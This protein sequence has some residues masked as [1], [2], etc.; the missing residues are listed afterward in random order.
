MGRTVAAVVGVVAMVEIAVAAPTIAVGF[1]GLAAGSVSAAVATAIIGAGLSIVKT[2]GDKLR[3]YGVRSS[4]QT[5]VP[6][7]GSTRD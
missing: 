2:A 4:P 1:L 5:G 3:A 6:I 7:S